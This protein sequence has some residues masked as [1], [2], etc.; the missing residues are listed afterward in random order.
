LQNTVRS[1][2]EFGWM[3]SNGDQEFVRR[4]IDD[5]RKIVVSEDTSEVRYALEQ[6]ERA[7]RVITD[8]MFRPTGLAADPG[9]KPEDEVTPLSEV[10]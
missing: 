6:L 8:A 7:A 1:F 2:G 4:T 5:A 3:L 10:T 9:A